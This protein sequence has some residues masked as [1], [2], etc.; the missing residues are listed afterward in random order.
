MSSLS[1]RIQI[2]HAVNVCNALGQAG[3][4]NMSR[5]NE[6]SFGGWVDH[7]FGA[8]G[9]RMHLQQAEYIIDFAT[10]ATAGD[11]QASNLSPMLAYQVPN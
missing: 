3:G 1:E 5:W 7:T 9:S 4:F 2:P 6:A 8:S 11:L 10:H